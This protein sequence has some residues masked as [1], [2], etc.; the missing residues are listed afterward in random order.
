MFTKLTQELL[1]LTATEKSEKGLRGVV[2]SCQ[3][4][5]SCG[6]LCCTFSGRSE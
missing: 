6:P 3:D 2:D 5:C 1:D 4:A